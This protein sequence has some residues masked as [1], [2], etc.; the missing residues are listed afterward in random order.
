MMIFF[1][2]IAFFLI[3]LYTD[4]YFYSTA[5]VHLSNAES[6]PV[7]TNKDKKQVII[8]LFLSRSSTFAGHI[9]VLNTNQT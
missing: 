3:S 7:V 4:K 6:I 8:L 2:K 5:R 1:T 9:S